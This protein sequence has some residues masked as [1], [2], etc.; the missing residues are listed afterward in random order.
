MSPSAEHNAAPA[1]DLPLH[2][3]LLQDGEEVILA[4]KPSG[5]FVLLVSWPV[6]VVAALVA[7]GV[8]VAVELFRA[9]LPQQTVLLVCLVVAFLRVAVACFQWL[10]HLYLLTNLR[11]L[12]LRGVFRSDVFD[13]PLKRIRQ[14]VLSATFLERLLGLGSLFFTTAES[15]APAAAWNCLS[16]PEEVRQTVEQAIRR[17][18]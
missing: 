6:V 2:E 4:I 18:R 8:Y 12:R 17:A 7:A 14:T 13:C 9:S 3:E 15:D 1:V 11:V 16:H 5:W 10:G